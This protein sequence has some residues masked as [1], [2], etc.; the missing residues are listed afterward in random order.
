MLSSS[1]LDLRYDD[2]LNQICRK[3][4]KGAWRNGVAAASVALERS[5]PGLLIDSSAA[6]RVDE[7]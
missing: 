1:Y 7:S 3:H 4:P 2:G 5:S 6:D